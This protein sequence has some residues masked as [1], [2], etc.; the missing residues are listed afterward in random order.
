MP[1]LPRTLPSSLRRTSPSSALSPSITSSGR[2]TTTTVVSA[3]RALHTTPLFRPTALTSLTLFRS[4]GCPSLSPSSFSPS[5]LSPLAQS[6]PS[7]I[8][9]GREQVRTAVYGA[10]YQP[11]QVKRKRTHGFLARKRSR[12]GRK[13]LVRRWNKGR[14]YLSH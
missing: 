13:V 11:S 9:F 14:K 1:R 6:S 10:E 12:N 2:P 3:S 5:I 4:S 7:S 8:G